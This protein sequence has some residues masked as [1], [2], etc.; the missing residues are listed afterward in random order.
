MIANTHMAA[1]WNLSARQPLTEY[2]SPIQ[3]LFHNTF[4]VVPVMRPQDLD[5]VYKLRYEVYCLERG[6]EDSKQFPQE[7][8]IDI[9]DARSIYTLLQHNKSGEFVGTARLIL[10]DQNHIGD[11]AYDHFPAQALSNHAMVYNEDIF[12]SNRTAEISRICYSQKKASELKLNTMEQRLILPGLLSGVY[13]LCDLYQVDTLMA[14]LEKRLIDRCHQIGFTP[15]EVGDSVEHKGTRH[16]VSYDRAKCADYVR[17]KN[18]EL[19]RI[20]TSNGKYSGNNGYMTL[21]AMS[22]QWEADGV[23]IDPLNKLLSS[24]I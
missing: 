2:Q 16:L 21:E 22:P 13:M 18:I 24:P 1:A 12:P 19:W 7:Q 9:Y 8:E 15:D 20:I 23:N 10:P 11:V 5:N 14:L 6:F 17:E 3:K 4:S